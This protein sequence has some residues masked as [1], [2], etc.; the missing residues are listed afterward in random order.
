ML[1]NDLTFTIIGLCLSIGIMSII[2]NKN[3]EIK[4]MFECVDNVCSSSSNSRRSSQ[5][6]KPIQSE[7][8]NLPPLPTNHPNPLFISTTTPITTQ[9]QPIFSTNSYTNSRTN[10]YNFDQNIHI[11][12]N[13]SNDINY[14]YQTE[15]SN[16][17]NKLF[18]QACTTQIQHGLKNNN[19]SNT[20]KLFAEEQNQYLDSSDLLPPVENIGGEHS[21]ANPFNNNINRNVIYDRLISTGKRSRLR[22]QADP[23][24]GDLPIVPVLPNTENKNVMFRP[25]ITPHLDLNAGAMNILGGNDYEQT[26]NFQNLM[27]ASKNLSMSKAQII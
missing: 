5:K 21:F 2:K 16:T 7:V 17:N 9:H 8:I 25:S 3:K 10:Q 20:A 14:P 19:V 18:N 22:A 24:R 11:N 15:N 12:Q 6:I 26:Q 23:I 4:E 13:D 27:Q 1:S